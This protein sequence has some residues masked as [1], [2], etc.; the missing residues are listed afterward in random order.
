MKFKANEQ[1]RPSF[2]LENLASMDFAPLSLSLSLARSVAL[3]R[4]L[5]SFTRAL[6][7]VDAYSGERLIIEQRQ[8]F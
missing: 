5:L 7:R 1:T 3:S 8:T 2:R 4:S 6:T